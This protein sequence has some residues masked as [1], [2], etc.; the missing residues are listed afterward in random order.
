MMERSGGIK[1]LGV[2]I[3]NKKYVDDFMIVKGKKVVSQI[4]KLVDLK[5]PQLSMILLK[6]VINAKMSFL[7]RNISWEIAKDK[8][9][10]RNEEDVFSELDIEIVKAGLECIG[11]DV[12]QAVEGSEKFIKF[13]LPLRRAGLGFRQC[14][15]IYTSIEWMSATMLAGNH[16]GVRETKQFAIHLN[17][18]KKYSELD[19]LIDEDYNKAVKDNYG[20]RVQK[21]C[22]DKLNERIEMRMVQ[23]MDHERK[24]AHA[25]S[26]MRGA[27][28][29]I[30]KRDYARIR[31]DEISIGIGRPGLTGEE[32]SYLVRRTLGGINPHGL[33]QDMIGM[34]CKK[35]FMNGNF[36]EHKI[37]DVTLRHSESRCKT[38]RGAKRHT[39]GQKALVL[40]GRSLGMGAQSSILVKDA[41]ID[42]VN[43]V[44]AKRVDVQLIDAATTYDLDITIRDPG[45]VIY[46]K[47]KRKKFVDNELFDFDI[48][49]FLR[50]AEQSKVDKYEDD[51]ALLF[52]FFYPI[53]ISSFGGIT[54]RTVK[55][56]DILSALLV[57]KDGVPTSKG[58]A[59]N[60]ILLRLQVATMK[61]MA[62]N[63]LKAIEDFKARGGGV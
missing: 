3:G 35:P 48:E 8:K 2:P 33:M 46:E 63:G 55:M 61:E 57:K 6:N 32:Y 7:A 47:K 1:I 62:K 45:A 9:H 21:V 41:N 51:C 44:G 20:V 10:F 12:N 29:W 52:H 59:F 42:A 38:V 40:I 30:F 43:G 14:G 39:A 49:Q 36:C 58:E 50:D 18:L 26:A 17:N 53:A 23:L 11:S 27:G 54:G 37:E 13:Y 60:R 4:K 16:E 31:R 56:L 5:E 25:A 24:V 15:G 22:V 34:Q 28:G 19:G